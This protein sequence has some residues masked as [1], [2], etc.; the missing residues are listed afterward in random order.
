MIEEA[1]EYFIEDL[2]SRHGV[3]VNGQRVHRHKLSNAD[4]IDF[5]FQDSYR[6]VF[7][8]EE[9]EIHRFMEQVSG[10]AATGAGNLSK[11]RSLMEVARALQSSLSTDDVLAAVVDAALSVTGAERGF[12][13]LRADGNALEGHL[14]RDRNG[15]PIACSDLQVPPALI[16]PSLHTQRQLLSIT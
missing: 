10:P 15:A 3:Y 6:V 9:D 2:K 11:L 4:R 8:L 14:A 12:L 16:H 1:G 7:S 5:G 13:L